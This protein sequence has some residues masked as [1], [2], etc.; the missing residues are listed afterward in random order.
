MEALVQYVL[1][2]S[3]HVVCQLRLA[4][5]AH[6]R[7]TIEEV[8]D[9]GQ[10]QRT[11]QDIR[12]RVERRWQEQGTSR[13]GQPDH[14]IALCHHQVQSAPIFAAALHPSQQALRVF[15]YLGRTN[16]PATVA[17]V[18]HYLAQLA[19]LMAESGSGDP[20]ATSVLTPLQ[21]AY[22]AMVTALTE[23]QSSTE[24]AMTG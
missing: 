2:Q 4:E 3:V 20:T 10:L 8:A 9:L 16:H 6:L 1:Q 11:Y 21:M 7:A 24:I 23:S 18:R 17:A 19:P 15:S 22:R 12:F 13:P 14:I 5:A